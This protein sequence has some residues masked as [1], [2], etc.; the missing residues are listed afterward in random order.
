MHK[1][2]KELKAWLM[3][4]MYRHPRVNAMTDKARL[5]V[6]DLY[7]FYHAKP[8]KMPKSWQ[9]KIDSAGLDRNVADYIAGMTDRFAL[10]EHL[11]YSY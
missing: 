7:K 1:Q 9:G 6:I 5:V 2:I 3:K 8:E 4:R 11:K 10:E